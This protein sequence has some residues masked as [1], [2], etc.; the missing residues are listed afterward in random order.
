MSAGCA[1]SRERVANVP[2]ES[3][4]LAISESSDGVLERTRA[5]LMARLGLPL[6]WW[7]LGVRE[8]PWTAADRAL[9]SG[10]RGFSIP[11]TPALMTSWIFEG[12][13]LPL[14]TT[15]DVVGCGGAKLATFRC[16][17]GADIERFL[18]ALAPRLLGEEARGGG[19][20]Y[21][22]I[23]RSFVRRSFSSAA[24]LRSGQMAG[25]SQKFLR[26]RHTTPATGGRGYRR[27]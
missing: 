8:S 12:R 3:A 13:R 25:I 26:A 4:G 21:W 10:A 23:N 24:I 15:S 2:L 18:R 9:V 22:R 20:S 14:S 17:T 1:L 5:D 6:G 19:A 7:S 16:A 27:R 11:R